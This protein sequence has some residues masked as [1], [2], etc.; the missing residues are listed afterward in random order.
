MLQDIHTTISEEDVQRF[1]ENGF[2]VRETSM[3]NEAATLILAR[4]RNRLECVINGEYDLGRS[5]TKVNSI[6][7]EFF[8]NG[9]F[10][11]SS[12]SPLKSNKFRTTVEFVNL[13]Q[14]DRLFK[15]LVTS[16]SLE[17][18]VKKLMRWDK[19]GC[20]MAQDRV[21]I[22]P[23]HSGPQQ[24]HRDTPYNQYM[25]DGACTV[26]IPLGQL[27][28]HCGTLEYCKGSHN[29]KETMGVHIPYQI[30]QG[31]NRAV[32]FLSASEEAK[33]ILKDIKNEGPESP[34]SPEDVQ[35]L[36]LRL[37]DPS[38]MHAVRTELGGCAFH[39][40]CTWHGWENNATN[41]WC[42]SISIHFV[43]GDSHLEEDLGP[44]WR[45]FQE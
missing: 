9:V 16:S 19:C 42:C 11:F 7:R 10:R 26:W 6:S 20:R 5:H 31:N 44:L 25:P 36:A 13:W 22:K 15:E 17:N 41:E 38:N 12:A 33:K 18:A 27:T 14:T 3:F 4:L 30:Y 29:W 2:Y 1:E 8:Q 37:V 39:N 21:W 40:G 45:Q 24:F 32:F 34:P 23:P 43:R 35:A 28:E